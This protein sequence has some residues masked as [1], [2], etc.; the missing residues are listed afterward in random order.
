MESES[1]PQFQSPF[2]LLGIFEESFKAISRNKK[3]LVRILL[4]VFLSI[5]LYDLAQDYML[6]SISKKFY[7]FELQFPDNPRI[8]NDFRSYLNNPT[9][10]ASMDIIHEFFLV[11]VI[12]YAYS[13]IIL[14]VYS[15]ATVFSSHEAYNAK[16]LGPKEMLLKIRS[17]W[18]KPLVTSFYMIL[19]TLGIVFL[20]AISSLIA[21]ISAVNSWSRVYF[22]GVAVLIIIWYIYVAA[23]WIF[24]IVVSV[25][26]EGFV[27]VKAIGRAAELMS[28][29]RL[30]A[31]ILIILFVVSYVVV[32]Q[33]N[34]VIITSY[35]LSW[36][37]RFAISI[38]FLN[39]LNS[40]LT[41]F[42]FVL[43]TVLYHERKTSHDE[44]E[45][46]GLYI[47]IAAGED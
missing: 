7:N 36:S 10:R 35:N 5:S 14:L 4:L 34:E 43:F 31:S 28:G 20:V 11:K 22:G 38:V 29:K 33:M 45:V 37:T 26:E 44:K 39:G 9:C 32:D 42:M 13:S 16:V 24:S 17:S 23:L 12:F 1:K 6:A 18:T 27:G 47:P 2:G 41:I 15:V 8:C 30:Q 25:L 21:I 40:S 46:K 19:I 3:L